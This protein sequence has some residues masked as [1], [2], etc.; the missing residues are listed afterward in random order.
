MKEL[1]HCSAHEAKDEAS[2]SMSIPSAVRKRQPGLLV[3]AISAISQ[4][5]GC[6]GARRDDESCRMAL[7]VQLMS[8]W[9]AVCRV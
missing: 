1:A 9:K 2:D 7:F 8:L 4:L 3:S 5:G 6:F